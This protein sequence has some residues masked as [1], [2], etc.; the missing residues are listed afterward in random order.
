MAATVGIRREDKSRWERR[1]PITPQMAR[2]LHDEHGIEF[3]AQ[4]SPVRIFREEEFELAGAKVQ[5]DLS[6]AGVV[7]GVKEIPIQYFQPGKTYVF[8]A[9]VIKGQ[10]YNMPMLKRMM[11]LGCNLIDYEKV[12]D[13]TGHR[14]IFFGWHA[15]VVSM[16]ESLW[17]LGRRLD[18]EGIANPFSSVR[19]TL[20]YGS[21]AEVREEVRRA[22]ERIRT[23]GLPQ[24]ITP[25]IVGVAGYGNVGRGIQE[26]L[27]DLPTI[28][29]EPA[30]VARIG[31]D[32]RASNRAVYRVLFKE[33]HAVAPN[34]PGAHFD[35]QD[36]YL[37]P[38][39]YHSIFDQ[40]VPYL[41]VL[42]NS[43]YWDA[44]Y[45]RLLTNSF[46]RSLFAGGRQPRLRVVG[47]A[48]CDIGGSIECTLKATE[49][50]DPVYVY[51]SHTEQVRMGVEGYGPVVL[52]VD[53]L[54][55]EIPRE[56]SEY[57]SE[58]LEPFIPAIANADYSVPFE[59]LALPSE[60]A[61]A[62]ILYHGK[63]TPD[64]RYIAEHLKT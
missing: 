33:E 46:L 14:L 24:A 5:E 27:S 38:Q 2:K 9:H 16:V 18:H 40:Y 61:R 13:E 32:P 54:P 52:A 51:D 7:F 56:A 47:D 37:H 25:L 23:E 26:I 11:E 31:N 1:V 42:M 44:R 62:M 34:D 45:P 49:P 21:L 20:T 36:Y 60:I 57:F 50:D 63:L 6:G 43:N 39:K 8:F 55:S 30:E 35:L 12:T 53:I 28:E 48:S 59:E 41:T 29:I 58:I 10:P 3:I 15:G 19:S 64:Y 4:P 22:G 17:A